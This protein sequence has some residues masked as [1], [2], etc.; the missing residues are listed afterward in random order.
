[1]TLARIGTRGKIPI[2]RTDPRGSNP[3]GWRYIVKRRILWP[4]RNAVGRKKVKVVNN[5]SV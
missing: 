2:E 4:V 3:V 5:A 1:M